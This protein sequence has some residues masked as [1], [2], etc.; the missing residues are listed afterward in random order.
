MAKF[1]STLSVV[2]L[3]WGVLLS[4]FHNFMEIDTAV[5]NLEISSS[6]H[7]SPCND[8]ASTD[9]HSKDGHACHF[10]CC[11]MVFSKFALKGSSPSGENHV[12]FDN[13][14]KASQFHLDLFRPPKA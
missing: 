6:T 9:S 7:A 8:G 3:A 13:V 10:G 4:T 12:N 1:F 11:A 2:V 14:G 5:G